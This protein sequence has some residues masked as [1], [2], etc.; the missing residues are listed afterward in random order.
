MAGRWHEIKKGAKISVSNHLTKQLFS[1]VLTCS[2]VFST[3]A[4]A[5]KSCLCVRTVIHRLLWTLCSCCSVVAY[6]FDSADMCGCELMPGFS[7]LPPT[8]SKEFKRTGYLKKKKKKKRTLIQVQNWYYYKGNWVLSELNVTPSSVFLRTLHTST[9][10]E[11]LA[12]NCAWS[13]S[14]EGER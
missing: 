14:A 8:P 12:Q 9:K 6:K 1:F 10:G 4:H 2:F 7:I 13:S 5:L 11:V 3:H